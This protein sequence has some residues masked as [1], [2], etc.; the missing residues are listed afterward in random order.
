MR[1]IEM[2]KEFTL[3][4]RLVESGEVIVE[5]SLSKV[6]FVN[7]KLFPWLILVPKRA[8]MREIIDLEDMDQ[9]ILF[10]EIVLVSKVIKKV[11]AP[12]KLNIA[13]LGNVVAQLHV[14]IVGR[15]END[16]AWP[17][18]MFNKDKEPYDKT[19]YNEL[20]EALA[21]QLTLN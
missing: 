10:Q 6:I 13:S 19:L 1:H 17:N 21:A 14:H 3:D 4:E 5:L 15:F 7:S 20:K 16:A 12:F 2:I 9:K 11:F 8:S 18:P